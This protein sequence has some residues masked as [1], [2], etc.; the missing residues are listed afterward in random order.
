[1]YVF[2]FITAASDGDLDAVKAYLKDGLDVNS[3]DWDKLTALVAAA[4]Q[5]HLKVVKLLL[6]KVGWFNPTQ[7]VVQRLSEIRS[8]SAYHVAVCVYPCRCCLCMW[9]CKMSGFVFVRT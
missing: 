1:M 8:S 5:G 3:Q 2:R 6:D 4:S 7:V 9:C